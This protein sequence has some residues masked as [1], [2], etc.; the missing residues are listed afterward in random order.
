[1]KRCRILLLLCLALYCGIGH[2]EDDKRKSGIEIQS[3]GGS[4][5]YITNGLMFG[6]RSV[7]YL[8]IVSHLNWGWEMLTGSARGGNL[9]KDNLT[10]AGLSM[11][12]DGP[13]AKIFHYDFS[14]LLG[15]GFGREDNLGFY[16]H[17]VV[18]QP[19]A[20]LGVTMIQGYRATFGVGYLIMPQVSGFNAVSFTIRLEH[21]IFGGES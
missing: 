2:A 12:Y 15:Y 18:I 1:M 6:F 14:V 9:D 5:G 11:G 3:F 21:R 4:N 13:L 16:G 8:E 10:Y 7:T 17:S 19:E 20:A